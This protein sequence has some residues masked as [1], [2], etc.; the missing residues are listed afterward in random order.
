MLAMR[1]GGE[2]GGV[3]VPCLHPETA[4]VQFA[5]RVII[6]LRRTLEAYQSRLA[7][8]HG[9]FYHFYLT[10]SALSRSRYGFVDAFNPET[11]WRDKDV[12]GIDVGITLL[13]AENYRI[14]HIG[15]N[16]HE[17]AGDQQNH[18]AGGVSPGA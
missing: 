12:I 17:S 1:S 6:S 10:N 4:P 11:G 16:I 18:G 2:G 5:I 3:D 15:G 9:F 14:G 8:E 7:Q 13:Q